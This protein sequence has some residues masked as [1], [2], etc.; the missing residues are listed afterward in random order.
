MR[1]LRR[2]DRFLMAIACL[3]LAGKIKESPRPLHKIIE[4]AY[5]LRAKTDTKRLEKMKDQAFMDQIHE[6]VVRAERVLLCTLGFDF[7]VQLSY[8][9]SLD[10]LKRLNLLE[11][12]EEG[13]QSMSQLTV[14]FLNDCLRTT[15]CLQYTAESIAAAA[16]SLAAYVRNVEVDHGEIWKYAQKEL[17]EEILGEMF[18]LYEAALMAQQ[19]WPK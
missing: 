18:S 16:V 4:V 11:R 7:D 2:N 15:M 12:K 9:R 6:H 3:F 1:S 17:A 14:N 13:D 19:V 10:I 8:Q 5:T